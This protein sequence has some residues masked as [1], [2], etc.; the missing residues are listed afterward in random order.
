MDFLSDS[1]HP[2]IPEAVLCEG[3]RSQVL[4]LRVARGVDAEGLFFGEVC[5]CCYSPNADG[6]VVH[7]SGLQFMV[8]A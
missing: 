2:Y 7:K 5:I 4:H 3:Y 6:W 1:Q 8:Q